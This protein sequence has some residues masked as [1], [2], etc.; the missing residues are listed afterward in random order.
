MPASTD[1]YPQQTHPLKGAPR[2]Q[3]FAT[4][5]GQP[6]PMPFLFEK[7]LRRIMTVLVTVSIVFVALALGLP[8]S[9]AMG[10]VPSCGA[11]ASGDSVG[12]RILS[13]DAEPALTSA[14]AF[15]GKWTVPRP[16]EQ[17]KATATADC[18]GSYCAPAFSLP[19]HHP[20]VTFS[21]GNEVWTAACDFLQSTE[22]SGAKRPPR[23][24][25]S[26]VSRA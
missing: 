10:S 18:C 24:T 1:D 4:T 15:T 2:R 16:G 26:Q 8:A 20:G 22:P 14:K 25:S 5:F 7:A 23:A 13:K 11:A 9:H 3:N 6:S 12:Y 17:N 19:A 21:R